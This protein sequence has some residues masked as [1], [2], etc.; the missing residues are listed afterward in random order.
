MR[1]ARIASPLDFGFAS[2]IS[3]PSRS[4]ASSREGQVEHSFDLPLFVE[5]L[6]ANPIKRDVLSVAPQSSEQ[7][8]V[9]ATAP[10]DCQGATARASFD[11]CGESPSRAA[12]RID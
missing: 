6:Q 3:L 8:T 9:L 1:A 7:M 12:P 10:R 2:V 5:T 11:R 4:G